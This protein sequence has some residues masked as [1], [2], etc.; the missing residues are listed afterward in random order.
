MAL[1]GYVGTA[2][3]LAL[4]TSTEVAL[5]M[6]VPIG[7]LG[8]I[9]WVGRMSFSSIFAHWADSY[10]EKGDVKGVMLM[11]WLPTQ[12]ILFVFKMIVV[13]LICV[14]GSEFVGGALANITG[15]PL[16]NGLSVIGGMVKAQGDRSVLISGKILGGSFIILTTGGIL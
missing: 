10:A 13:T 16:F 14:Y 6:A 4:N 5:T 1:A 12:A 7:L 2:F 15:S 9:V 11:N 8:T 3:A